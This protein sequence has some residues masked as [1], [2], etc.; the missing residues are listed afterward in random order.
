MFIAGQFVTD[1]RAKVDIFNDIFGKQCSLI[2]NSSS[3]P[4]ESVVLTNDKFT[5]L[6]ICKEEI[7][8]IIRSLN[9]NKAHGFDGISIRILQI[10]DE[11]ICKPLTIIF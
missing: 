9:A 7:L 1:F 3:V 8:K 5:N 4:N 11:S 6:E 10:C 2:E